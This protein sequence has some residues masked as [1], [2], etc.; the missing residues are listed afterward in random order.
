MGDLMHALPALTDACEK[1]PGIEFDWVVDEAFA[2]VPSWHPAVKNI[3]TSAHRRWKKSLISSW[4]NDEFSGF[5]NNLNANEYDV[6]IDA[7]NNVK[8][9]FIS[10]LRKGNVH[11]MDMHSVAE[12]PAFLAYKYTHSIDKNQHAI[13]RQ[14]ELFAKSL[15][16]ELPGTNVNYGIRSDAFILP[17]IALES[18]FLFLVHNASWTTKLW[19]ENYWFELIGLA[20]EENYNV[21]LPGGNS[22]ELARA[23]L[24]A[25]KHD[26]AIALPRM[27]LSELGGIISKAEGAICCDTG[28]AH[29]TAIT[30]TPS[31]TMYGP[32]S[33]E[34]I[35][36]YG[37]GQQ[38]LDAENPLFPCSPCYKRICMY[39]GKSSAMSACMNSF[40]PAQ[41]WDMLRTQIKKQTE[42]RKKN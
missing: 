4:Q 18:P 31:V 30:G 21:V 37:A 32:T 40:K 10:F 34:L 29:L 17:S 11:G 42:N 7:Q 20:K 39:D 26:N 27:T 1:Y 13:T 3:Y 19:N 22:E 12:Q 6:V 24:I 2:E 41:I 38:H 14:R 16:Y 36:T 8:S 23:A 33:V 25:S 15:G 28:L 5:R 9:S 35:G